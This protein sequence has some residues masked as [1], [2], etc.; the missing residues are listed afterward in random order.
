MYY[1]KTAV[2]SWRLA[3]DLK[4]DLEEQ[5]RN[6]GTSLSSLLEQIASEWLQAHR[7]RSLSDAEQQAAIRQCAVAAIGS[8]RGGD[9]SRA[10]RAGELVHEIIRRKHDKESR[11]H[12][13]D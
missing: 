3:I 12:R 2:Y 4:T 10:S 8:V 11:A 5:A 9:P 13:P 1:M 6:Q 7:D